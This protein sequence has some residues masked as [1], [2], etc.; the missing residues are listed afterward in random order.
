[1][2][3]LCIKTFEITANNRSKLAYKI[4]YVVTIIKKHEF[5]TIRLLTKVVRIEVRFRNRNSYIHLDGR[6]K[7]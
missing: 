4:R 5:S 7:T 6:I 2:N 1:M 3:S